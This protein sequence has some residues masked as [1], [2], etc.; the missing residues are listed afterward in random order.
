MVQ[1]LVSF[2]KVVNGKYYFRVFCYRTGL[3]NFGR[4]CRRAALV[5]R[6]IRRESQVAGWEKPKTLTG[7]VNSNSFHNMEQGDEPT[8]WFKYCRPQ[9]IP[10]ISKPKIIGV[11][12]NNLL[13]FSTYVK[14]TC[15]KL[16]TCNITQYEC[17]ATHCCTGCHLMFKQDHLYDETKVKP[18]KQHIEMLAK[19]YLLS[20]YKPENSCHIIAME[21]SPPRNIR[22]SPIQLRRRY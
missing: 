21:N 4:N 6:N 14:V 8:T 13:N 3:M 5:R 11:T 20:S 1:L 19:Q 7:E 18:V 2:L 12:F 10:T 17:R 15:E 9:H 22:R 16:Q